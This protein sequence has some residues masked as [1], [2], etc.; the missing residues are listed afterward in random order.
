MALEAAGPSEPDLELL[1]TMVLPVL[2][3]LLLV[4]SLLPLIL[5]L[6]L[7]L[8]LV[9]EQLLSLQTL[10][11]LTDVETKRRVRLSA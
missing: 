3:S 7:L 8:L 4:L 5:L 2:F 1:L 9:M 6:L 10:V 11:L